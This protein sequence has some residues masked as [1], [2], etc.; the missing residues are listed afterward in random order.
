[1][2]GS[3]H[4]RMLAR[5]LVA[6]AALAL[7]PATARANGRFPAANQFNVMP[8]KP[9]TMM[10]RTTFGVLLSTDK[11]VTWNW[12]CES[13]MGFGSTVEDPSL[14]IT[15][16]GAIVAGLFNG[17]SVSPD[18]GC[19]WAFVGG[20][21]A[22]QVIAD[23]V[24]RPDS[25]NTALALTSTYAG[26]GGVSL[27]SSQIYRSADGGATWAAYGAPIDPTVLTETL[28]VAA[29]DPHRV[30]VTG[31]RGTAS[32]LSASLFVSTD[33]AAH[34]TEEPIPIDL[35]MMEDGVYIAAVDPTM[36]DR[37]YVRTNTSTATSSRLLVTNGAGDAGATF[38][39]AYTGGPMLGF[40]LSP[41]GSSVY[42]GGPMDGLQVAAASDLK[43]AKQ[44]SIHVQCLTWSGTT[45][46]ACSDE[47]SGFI[48]GGSADQGKTWSPILHLATIRGPLA[49]P[50]SSAAQEQCPSQWPA[51]ASTLG[52]PI[53]AG[54]GD[55]GTGGGGS[56]GCGCRA[57]DGAAGGG[58]AMLVVIVGLVA[59]RRR[60]R[61][62]RAG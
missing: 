47:V 37:V 33:D 20:P 52:I 29:S 1:M 57:G 53:D 50:G 31:L 35:G 40:A 19:D 42:L 25:P 4:G 54:L 7:A 39:V 18:T 8:G 49:C 44:S 48:L 60:R 22:G 9:S 21:L 24:V 55:G 14:G 13:A 2:Q 46:Y 28:E 59:G 5:A 34:W 23:V 51:V 45:L 36:P 61:Q 62:W 32:T 11:G 26:N 56:R 58:A 27:F 41:D 12:V 43:F 17:L 16:S 10:L 30:Y 15:S 38:T 6:T 3:C